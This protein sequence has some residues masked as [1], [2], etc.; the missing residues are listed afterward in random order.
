M[1]GKLKVLSSQ[2]G[3]IHYYIRDQNL[4]ESLEAILYYYLYPDRKIILNSVD[5]V[6][7]TAVK[8]RIDNHKFLAWLN[9]NAF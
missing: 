5:T 1:Q 4:F 8:L 2:G 3:S 9:R 7:K 6:A